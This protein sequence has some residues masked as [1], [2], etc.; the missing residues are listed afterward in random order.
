MS[1]EGRDDEDDEAGDQSRA[2]RPTGRRPAS[3]V[4]SQPPPDGAQEESSLHRYL[5]AVDEGHVR[6]AGGPEL[7]LGAAEVFWQDEEV[8][9]ECGALQAGGI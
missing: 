4:V 2:V 9:G 8:E 7:L 6:L 5:H 3:L 1:G